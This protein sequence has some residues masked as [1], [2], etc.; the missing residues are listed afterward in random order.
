[1]SATNLTRDEWRSLGIAT[2]TAATCAG[3]AGLVSWA[4][5]EAKR[6]VGER[7]AKA[8]AAADERAARRASLGAP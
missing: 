7:R 4:I 1:M 3:A 2:L 8:K 5:E 6:V